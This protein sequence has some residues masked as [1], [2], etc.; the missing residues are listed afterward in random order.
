MILKT[1]K[2]QIVFHDVYNIDHVI[3]NYRD[4]IFLKKQKL[5]LNDLDEIIINI[6]SPT[7]LVP[8]MNVFIF[9]EAFMRG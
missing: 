9:D 7:I 1:I 3:G 4:V 6:L 2:E 5:F 8:N